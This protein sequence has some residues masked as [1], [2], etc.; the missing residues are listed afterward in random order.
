ML[1]HVETGRRTEIDL[2]NGALLREAK[3][4]GIAC[5]FNE[6]VV[7]T[8]KSIEARS[9]ARAASPTLDESALE[10]AARASPRP[11]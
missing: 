6:A 9:A 4:L 7:M 8:V 1:Q 3:A 5:P 10:A 2:L 11:D